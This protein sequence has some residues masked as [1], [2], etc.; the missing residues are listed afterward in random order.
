MPRTKSQPQPSKL[1]C[2]NNSAPPT[3]KKNG[4]SRQTPPWKAS[5][6]SRPVGPTARE[7]TPSAVDQS[8]H[9]LELRGA[10]KIQRRAASKV[11]RQQRRNLQQLQQQELA[12]HSEA[13]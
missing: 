6:R 9:L 3:T 1:S 4:S 2:L 7:T 5:P 13:T 8:P 12:R 10:G 11:R